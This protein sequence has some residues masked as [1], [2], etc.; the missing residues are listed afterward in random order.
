MLELII[1]SKY[2]I[3]IAVVFSGGAGYILGQR[4]ATK[5]IEKAEQKAEQKSNI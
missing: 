5:I 3:L 1:H 2:F 4:D